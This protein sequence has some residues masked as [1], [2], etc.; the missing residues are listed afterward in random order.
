VSTPKADSSSPELVR[1]AT[2][3]SIFFC[4]DTHHIAGGCFIHAFGLPVC[5]SCPLLAFNNVRMDPHCLS[6]R[7]R[8]RDK[9]FLLLVMGISIDHS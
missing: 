2:S 6:L 4:R 8:N 3:S 7:S 9:A 1:E 5:D